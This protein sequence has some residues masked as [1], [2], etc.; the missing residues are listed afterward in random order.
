MLTQFCVHSWVQKLPSLLE[1]HSLEV[2]VVERRRECVWQRQM[3]MESICN[4][5]AL[6]ATSKIELNEGPRERW[7]AVRER[8][9][10]A[11]EQARNGAYF[12][13]IFQVVV[14][15]KPVDVTKL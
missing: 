15:R 11:F 7:L 5:A 2:C 8:S 12:S 3:L 14:V 13:Q 1:E 4:I 9:R 6:I 10:K